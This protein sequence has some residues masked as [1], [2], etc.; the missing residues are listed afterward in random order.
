MVDSGASKCVVVSV[1]QRVAVCCSVLQSVCHSV[2]GGSMRGKYAIGRQHG[3]LRRLKVCCS[4]CV[5]VCCSA[6]QRFAVSVLQCMQGRFAIGHQHG[7]L[8][9]L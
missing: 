4:A 6:L 7:R 2:C 1:L 8:K 3:R 9:R 5:A